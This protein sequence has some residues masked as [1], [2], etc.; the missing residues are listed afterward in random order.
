MKLES[1]DPNSLRSSLP[2]YKLP[3]RLT[4]SST[5]LQTT[6][7]NLDSL[8]LF[9][10]TNVPTHFSSLSSAI[11]CKIMEMYGQ[12]RYKIT[13]KNKNK[14]EMYSLTSTVPPLYFLSLS[15]SHILSAILG[16][17]KLKIIFNL[18]NG[19]HFERI[20]Y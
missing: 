3:F 12:G 17:P 11:L 16:F 1:Q 18:T 15:L 13:L 20:V 4:H 7:C 9:D 8:I 5:S 2:L 14:K 10:Q 6:V 19:L